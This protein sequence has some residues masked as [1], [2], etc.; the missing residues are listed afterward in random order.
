MTM[1]YTVDTPEV[2]TDVRPG[3]RVTAKVYEGDFKSLIRL[4]GCPARGY[5]GFLSQE[6]SANHKRQKVVLLCTCCC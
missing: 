5:A 1:P 3:D 4:E 2:L 6:I